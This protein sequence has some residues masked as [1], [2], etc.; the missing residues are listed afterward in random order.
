MLNYSRYGVLAMMIKYLLFYGLLNLITSWGILWFK[1]QTNTTK[2][3]FSEIFV[4]VFSIHLFQEKF[5]IRPHKLEI[6]PV[7]NLFHAFLAVDIN[8]KEFIT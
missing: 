5:Y 6:L 8:L 1:K 2:I 4:S 3:R 7:R